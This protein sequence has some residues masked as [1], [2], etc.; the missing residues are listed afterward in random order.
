MPYNKNN[1]ESYKK[2]KEYQRKWKAAYRLTEEGRLKNLESQKKWRLKH[3]EEHRKRNKE[4][5]KNNR[6]IINNRIRSRYKNDPVWRIQCLLRSRMKDEWNNSIINKNAYHDFLGCSFEDLKIH[7]ESLFKPGMTWDNKGSKWHIDH[8][9]PLSLF[10]RLHNSGTERFYDLYL[11]DAFNY[12][13]LRPEWA[14]D[15]IQRGNR[16]ILIK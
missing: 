9:I 8:I 4:Y 6:S 15:N 14:K 7:I 11:K 13:N 2:H 12:T 3:I 1:E 16:W 5:A 10:T